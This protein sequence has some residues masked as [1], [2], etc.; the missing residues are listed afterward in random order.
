MRRREKW[1]MTASGIL[2]LTAMTVTGVYIYNSNQGKEPENNVVDFSAL[3]GETTQ[4]GQVAQAENS[5]AQNLTSGQENTGE[6]DYDPYYAE[7]DRKLNEG[8]SA[9]L[10]KTGE[11]TLEPDGGKQEE[12]LSVGL[13]GRRV[14]G[15]MVE[16]VAEYGASA[17]NGQYLVVV[18]VNGW[19]PFL[20]EK[21]RLYQ[22][23]G[24]ELALLEEYPGEE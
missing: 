13:S 23:S 16:W 6:L 3:E 18:N 10:P 14:L 12:S 17:E 21:S 7:A 2:V 20:V 24:N 9:T 22:V 8:S 19:L 1:I 5:S 4:D 15:V 11:G